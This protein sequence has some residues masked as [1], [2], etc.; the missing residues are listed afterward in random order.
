[1]KNKLI[2]FSILSLALAFGVFAQCTKNPVYIALGVPGIYPTPQQGI[3]SGTIGA[4][5]SQNFTVI[6]PGDTTIV[7]SDFN[8]IL[9]STP[10]MVQ[11]NS[12]KVSGITGMPSGLSHV[13]DIPSCMWPGDSTGCFLISG[14]PS[15]SGVFTVSVAVVL[16]VE[17]PMFGPA[18]APAQNTDYILAI[19]DTSTPAGIYVV[20]FNEFEVLQNFPNP[21]AATTGITFFSPGAAQIEFSIYNFIGEKVFYKKTT[22]SRGIN[23]IDVSRE[24]LIEGAYIYSL[25]NGKEVVTKKMVV[26]K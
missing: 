4:P 15:Q 13:C 5:Y 20:D 25:T 2:I 21:F 10:V 12:M 26:N 6:A 8:P 9:P 18:D 24:G 3:D 14:V 17:I 11:V 16:N 19:A 23:K 1:M 22:A 7:P